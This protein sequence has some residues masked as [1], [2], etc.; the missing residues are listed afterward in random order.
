[1]ARH[2]FTI[3][4]P[5]AKGG[6]PGLEKV[7]AG[8]QHAPGANNVLV[9]Q[10]FPEVHFASFVIFDD[11]LVF[12]NSVSGPRNDYLRAL[13]RYADLDRIYRYC[14]DYPQRRTT[15]DERYSYLRDHYHKPNLRHVSTP[16]R[17]VPS[18]REDEEMVRQH[19]EPLALL[20]PAR[21]LDPR[22]RV[23]ALRESWT[24]EAAKPYLAIGGSFLLLWW[25]AWVWGHVRTPWL[26]R[27][28][29]VL[30]ADILLPVVFG[31]SFLLK[32]WRTTPR[33]F[34][35]RAFTAAT[36]AVALLL[37]LGLAWN[38]G[39]THWITAL[40]LLGLG[41]VAIASL[42]RIV[43]GWNREQIAALRQAMSAT[44]AVE[45][46]NDLRTEHARTSPRPYERERAAWWE[47]LWNWRHWLFLP[48][49][50]TT[51]V[52]A[53]GRFHFEA[54][55]YWALVAAFAVEAWWLTILVGWPPYSIWSRSRAVIL[56]GVTAAGTFVLESLRVLDPHAHLHKEWL[57]ADL[58]VL[59]FDWHALIC[60][61]ALLVTW[62][63][64]QAMTLPAPEVEVAPPSKGEQDVIDSVMRQE[65]HGVQNHMV[66][67]ACVGTSLARTIS[68]RIFLWSLDRI[69]YRSLLPDVWRGKLFG[70][71]TVHSAQWVL[72]D[73]GRFLFLTNYDHSFTTYL[74]DFGT[75]IPSG[76][77]KIWG[78]S[79]G[80]PGMADV[81]RF[82]LFVRKA[83]VPHQ[84]WYRAYEDVSVR[85]IWNNEQIRRNL[86]FDAG[87][88]TQML[89][90]LR[91]F[92]GAPSIVPGITHAAV[93]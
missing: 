66:L 13:A 1:M 7:L 23:P 21:L 64:L 57:P 3:V 12:E 72:L 27:D 45:F 82:K 38:R 50:M 93:R 10:N 68:L 35:A 18:I 92:G 88:E 89:A 91:R 39:T 14:A 62:F 73:D 69:F 49:M 28:N 6:R 4:T 33:S 24:W 67:A 30:A 5:I 87:D 42:V 11:V 48:G 53:S 54:R 22:A 32:S 43:A 46:W 20:R 74:N 47:H 31:G 81:E 76:I 90:T 83:M 80:N 56:V 75:Q 78:T 61:V 79:A 2:V 15:A 65:D 19:L 16:Y 51:L 55:L 85:R 71:P 86:A 29:A 52:Y 40:A 44:R 59:T 26:V 37:L 17:T 36:R 58:Q 8:I 84:V 63:A 41:A 60:A 25:S 9:F 34:R 70:I 77:Q